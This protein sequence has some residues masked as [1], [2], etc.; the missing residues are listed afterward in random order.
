MQ[1]STCTHHIFLHCFTATSGAQRFF[2]SLI[3]FP[4]LAFFSH[5]V[6]IVLCCLCFLYVNRILPYIPNTLLINKYT[7]IVNKLSGVVYPQAPDLD[8]YAHELTNISGLTHIH[9]RTY[10]VRIHMQSNDIIWHLAH[11]H[12]TYT[13]IRNMCNTTRMIL[14]LCV[15]VCG[16]REVCVCMCTMFRL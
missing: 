2:L 7:N 3:F 10:T 5:L 12:R 4:E 15:C 16:V 8:T 9:I 11:E 13:M 14:C 6:P 1:T